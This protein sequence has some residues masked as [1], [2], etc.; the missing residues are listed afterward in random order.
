MREGL[1]VTLTGNGKIKRHLSTRKGEVPL[2]DTTIAN[3]LILLTDK[4]LSTCIHEN[5]RELWDLAQQIEDDP[6]IYTLFQENLRMLLRMEERND[7]IHAVLTRTKLED[8]VTD[9]PVTPGQMKQR[10]IM[11]LSHLTAVRTAQALT[12]FVLRKLCLHKPIPELVW[13]S[14]LQRSYATAVFT[15]DDQLHVQYLFRAADAYYYFLLQHLIASSPNIV[16]CGYCGRYF[17]PKTRKKTLYCDRIVRNGRTCKQIAPY[18]NWKEKAAANAVISEFN[19]AKDTM[20]HRFDR[21]GVRKKPSPKDL[22]KEQYDSWLEGATAVRDRYLARDLTAEEAL[23]IIRA[24][25]SREL[26]EK[27]SAELKL[28]TSGIVS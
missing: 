16:Q 4:H 6:S 3:E 23:E 13:S 11:T 18:L 1:Y 14:Y 15:L 5:A 25:K 22:T 17:T 9:K 8:E 24:S 21:T 2:D 28:E 7:L 10:F 19:H 27:D 20:F 26:R 12:D